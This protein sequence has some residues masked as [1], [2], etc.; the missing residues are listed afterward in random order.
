M[1][2]FSRIPRKA[3]V[4]VVREIW[5]V[6]ASAGQMHSWLMAVEARN[7]TWS[8]VH[9]CIRAMSTGEGGGSRTVRHEPLKMV[10]N[11][12]SAAALVRACFE[13]H[14]TLRG[15]AP[16]RRSVDTCAAGVNTTDLLPDVVVSTGEALR[17]G[18]AVEEV[19]STSWPRNRTAGAADVPV[20]VTAD[21][22][23][24]TA[25]IG[26]AIVVA[27]VAAQDASVA[28]DPVAGCDL[29]HRRGAWLSVCRG[30]LAHRLHLQPRFGRRPHGQW[31][32]RGLRYSS[33]LDPTE[34]SPPEQAH[35][36]GLSDQVPLSLR[37]NEPH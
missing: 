30:G 24:A 18:T 21:I 8:S 20:V 35:F 32:A 23:A 19:V 14:C 12:D 17:S 36:P 13:L 37:I 4:E 15:N 1:K 26:T 6:M 3:P 7:L 11:V 27:A 34:S 33:S 29:D 5:T 10:P 28:D 22:A 31:L 16:P 2:S 9:R 25:A